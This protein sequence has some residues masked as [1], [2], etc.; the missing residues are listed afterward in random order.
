M[1]FTLTLTSIPVYR[2]Y[3]ITF[4]KFI[5]DISEISFNV[6]VDL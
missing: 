1:D 6:I 4:C 5:M 3:E 2:P